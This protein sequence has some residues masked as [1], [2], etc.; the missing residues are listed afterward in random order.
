MKTLLDMLGQYWYWYFLASFSVFASQLRRQEG[1]QHPQGARRRQ[2]G[3]LQGGERR[4]QGGQR[5]R[6]GGQRQRQGGQLQGG[7]RS[8][9]QGWKMFRMLDLVA[10]VVGLLMGLVSLMFRSSRSVLTV[11]VQTHFIFFLNCLISYN[12]RSKVLCYFLSSHLANKRLNAFLLT[13]LSGLV[14]TYHFV[15]PEHDLPMLEVLIFCILLCPSTGVEGE[16]SGEA[17]RIAIWFKVALGY[18]VVLAAFL[19]LKVLSLGGFFLGRIV[20]SIGLQTHELSLIN[21]A[22]SMTGSE[23]IIGSYEWLALISAQISSYYCENYNDP[24]VR[25]LFELLFF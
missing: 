7:E 8:V 1:W 23:F 2:G 20:T 4:R 18:P 12:C 24:G 10:G 21:S 25:S 13:A 3:Q 5:R 22:V 15:L 9:C 19:P 17:G 14:D 11:L 6:Q 16:E